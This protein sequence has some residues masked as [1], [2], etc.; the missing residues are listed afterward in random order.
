M[1][2]PSSNCTGV[3]PHGT[4][5]VCPPDIDVSSGFVIRVTLFPC[6][7]GGTA[8]QTHWWLDIPLGPLSA[9]QQEFDVYYHDAFDSPGEP[10]RLLGHIAFPVISLSEV[11]ALSVWSL[12]TLILAL[13]LAAL[14]S[15]KRSAADRRRLN[16]PGTSLT[17]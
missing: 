14:V 7:Q 5:P 12:V 11:P 2:Q 16:E 8:S 17:D 10:P 9:G 1:R 4:P 13:C 15:L 3:W 6:Y